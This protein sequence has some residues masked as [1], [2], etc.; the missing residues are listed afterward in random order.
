MKILFQTSL[1]A[2]KGDIAS[3]GGVGVWAA[4]IY[5]YS[6]TREEDRY[7]LIPF[8]LPV[9]R[10]ISRN[11]SL[12]H[13]LFYGFTD[14]FYKWIRLI[15]KLY[16]EK[17]E[18]VHLSNSA[19][20]SLY[21]DYLYVKT[22]HLFKRKVVIHFHF[23]RIPELA[24]LNNWEWRMLVRLV[25]MADHVIVL[26]N[27]SYRTL[28][29]KGFENI[30]CIPNPISPFVLNLI[31]EQ[32]PARDNRTILFV[33]QVFETKGVVE[34]VEACKRIPNIKLK[35]L[36]HIFDEMKERLLAL[37]NEED[38][39]EIMGKKDMK[40]VMDEM[41]KCDIFVLPTYT[42]GFPNVILEA[43]ASRCAIITTP[44]GAIPQMLEEEDGKHYAILVEPKDTEQL[45]QAI[46]SLLDNETLKE[47]MR[48]NVRERV[49]QRYNISSVWA[50]MTEVWSNIVK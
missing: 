37:S 44:V 18:V 19:S 50:Q 13:R 16:S 9:I 33:G 31:P 7:E 30:S 4:H 1:N 46:E 45:Y 3:G 43:M 21:R 49:I 2:V 42:E 22:I 28:K 10:S 17:F 25:H 26:D 6:K 35:I 39:L 47:E 38:W 40:G 34:L 11:K 8:Y 36:G 48:H 23:G 5:R 32:Q 27:S 29:E 24:I 12:L 14:Y 41:S 20:L 15:Y